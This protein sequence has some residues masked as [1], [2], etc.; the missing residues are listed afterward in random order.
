[1]KERKFDRNDE[2]NVKSSNDKERKENPIQ[3]KKKE[4]KK[5]KS[6]KNGRKERKKRKSNMNRK[7]EY[8]FNIICM[9]KKE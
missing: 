4:R 8:S 2:R 3:I 6:N 9:R 1:M 5:Y 7:K